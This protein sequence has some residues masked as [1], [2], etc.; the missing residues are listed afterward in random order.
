MIVLE[1]CCRNGIRTNLKK[2]ILLRLGFK[3]STR[4]IK[5]LL[6]FHRVDVVVFVC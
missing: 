3:K 4:L 6:L 1:L 5:V 2:R